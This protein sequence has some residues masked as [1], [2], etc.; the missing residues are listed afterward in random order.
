M[1]KYAAISDIGVHIIKLLRESMIPEPIPNPEMIGLCSPYDKGD[2]VLGLWLYNIQEIGEYRAVDMIRQLDGRQNY[3]PLSLELKYMLTV[4]SNAD[5][6]SRAVDEQR[7]L[8]RAMQI[9]YDNAIIQPRDIAASFEEN[10][11]SI[12]I[13]LEPLSQE[14]K[15]RIWPDTQ[16]PYR[17]SAFYRAEPI[18]IR[19]ER[20]RG[21]ARVT[22]LA[23]KLGGS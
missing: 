13:S 15:Y 10:E 4:F 17:L 12:G 22:D 16:K 21:G 1:A 11:P 8:G 5:I 23:V 18:Q 9:L 14:E 7:I 2:Y 3:P 19:S 6:L 20:T